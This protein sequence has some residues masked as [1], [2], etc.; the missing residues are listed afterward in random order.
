[1]EEPSV[2]EE[3]A[4]YVTRPGH[5]L[6]PLTELMHLYSRLKPGKTIHTWIEENSVAERGID[7]HRFITFGVIKGFLRRVHRWPFLLSRDR[8]VKKGKEVAF[9]NDSMSTSPSSIMT[10]TKNMEDSEGANANSARSR[11]THTPTPRPMPKQTSFPPIPTGPS[12]AHSTRIGSAI[13][14]SGPG[15]P[16][17]SRSVSFREPEPKDTIL[18]K[19]PAL[20]DGSRHTDELCTMFRVSWPELEKYL[21]VMKEGE[22][23]L[24]SD[25]NLGRD[26]AGLDRTSRVRIIYH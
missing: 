5:P 22:R 4:A 8:T 3:C 1:V 2:R 25:E 11:H 20:L 16:G 18:E 7:V 17:L 26:L 9:G 15:G 19:L 6:L 23:E 21:T 14:Q 12:K 24:E 10:I 13:R